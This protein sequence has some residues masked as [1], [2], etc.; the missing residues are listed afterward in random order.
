MYVLTNKELKLLEME[1][2]IHRM[3]LLVNDGLTYVVGNIKVDNGGLTNRI[4]AYKLTDT[5]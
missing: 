3:L 4:M 5:F 2:K 1:L